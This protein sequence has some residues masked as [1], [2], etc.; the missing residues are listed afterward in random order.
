MLPILVTFTIPFLGHTVSIPS[1]GFFLALA[2]F[3]AIQLGHLRGLELGYTPE[4][5]GTLYL[6]IF[7]S[8]MAGARITYIL[9]EWQKVQASPSEYLLTLKGGGVFY[10]GLITSIVSVGL[11]G[12]AKGIKKSHLADECAMPIAIG[13]LLGRLGCFCGG[14]CYGRPT[15]LPWGCAFGLEGMR[16]HPTQLYEAMGLLIIF[17][18]LY[19]MVWRP[20]RDW[21]VALT[22]MTLYGCL[23]FVVEMY[24]GDDRGPAILAGLSVSQTASLV[25][26]A[27]AAVGWVSIRR[28]P[29]S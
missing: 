28:R 20:H 29:A 7:V 23:R 18:V 5:L 21:S 15:D 11:F 10:G 4:F 13:H 24:R 16:R 9:T 17:I 14:C 3:F 19:R 25:F 26:L 1:Y 12:V 6:V 8:A 27:V 22:Y 2:F